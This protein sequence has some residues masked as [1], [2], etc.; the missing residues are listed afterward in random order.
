MITWSTRFDGDGNQDAA[1]LPRLFPAAE[2]LIARPFP[3]LNRSRADYCRMA[4]GMHGEKG[5][6]RFRVC[7]EYTP[8]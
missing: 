5:E 6:D 3:F 8:D 2:E 1:R 4:Q 7:G